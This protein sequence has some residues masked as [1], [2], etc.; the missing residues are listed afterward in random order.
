MENIANEA[1]IGILTILIANILAVLGWIFSRFFSFW[2]YRNNI[3]AYLTVLIPLKIFEVKRNYGILL[4]K[5]KD[6]VQ[7]GAPIKAVPLVYKA[8]TL[9]S[10][11]C[12]KHQ[13]IEYLTEIEVGKFTHFLFLLREVEDFYEGLC[14]HLNECKDKGD[15]IDEEIFKHLHEHLVNADHLLKHLPSPETVKK[16]LFDLPLVYNDF[17]QLRTGR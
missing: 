16:G 10:L 3:R 11:S 1:V 5:L 8:D 2:S 4:K 7:L 15:V 17:T 6:D 14:N 12:V 9:E 13:A